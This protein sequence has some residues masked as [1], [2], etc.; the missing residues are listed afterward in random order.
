LKDL[1]GGRKGKTMAKVSPFLWFEKDAEQAARFYVSLVADSHFGGITTL[2][3]DTPSGPEGSVSVVDFTLAGQAYVA[4]N[5]GRL[6]PFNHA[7][8]FMIS[9]DTQEEIDRIWDAHLKNGGA[10]QQCGWLKDRWGL[11][12][13]ITPRVLMEMIRNADRAAAKRATQAMMKMIKLD[14]AALQ[15][16]FD[17]R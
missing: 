12:W 17:E 13:Q 4:M 5:A 7:V 11:Y 2:P 16:A 6:D 3:S 9:C 14:I 8:S 15:K 1:D 10:E